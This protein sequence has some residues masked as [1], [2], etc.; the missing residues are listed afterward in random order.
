MVSSTIGALACCCYIFVPLSASLYWLG[1]VLI[2]VA[3]VAVGRCRLTLDSIKTHVE[4]A[5]G[6]CA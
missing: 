3:N 5:Y 2:V 1:G 4:S 6:L